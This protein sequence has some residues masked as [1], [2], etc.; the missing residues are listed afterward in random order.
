MLRYVGGGF[1]GGVPARD[2]TEAEVKAGP[3]DGT[4]GWDREALVGTGLYVEAG[5]GQ[6]SAVSP[7]GAGGAGGQPRDTTRDRPAREKGEKA[8]IS[9]S[10]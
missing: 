8:Q 7:A 9:N 1:I 3:A 2:L 4:G 6:Q 5:S 10:K